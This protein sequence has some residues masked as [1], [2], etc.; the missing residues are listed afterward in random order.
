MVTAK[1]ERSTL[2]TRE[3]IE[4]TAGVSWPVIRRWIQDEGFPAK[5][6]GRLWISDAGLI[7]SWFRHRLERDKGRFTT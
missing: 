2:I 3:E 6:M 4:R 7:N 1:I 5:K